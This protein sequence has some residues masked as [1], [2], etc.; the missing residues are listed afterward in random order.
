MRIPFYLVLISS[1]A[2]CSAVPTYVDPVPS[3]DT[4]RIRVVSTKGLNVNLVA[5]PNYEGHCL[6]VNNAEARSIPINTNFGLSINIPKKIGMPFVDEHSKSFGTEYYVSSKEPMVFTTSSNTLKG[7][8]SVT[9]ISAFR[10]QFEAGKDY[11]I[12]LYPDPKSC[13]ASLSD[14]TNFKPGDKLDVINLDP[15]AVKGSPAWDTL[16]KTSN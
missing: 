9:C 6:K 4:A 8:T 7:N 16:C 2:A 13:V 14:I 3:Q 5:Y 12:S 11:Q 1:L 15:I 10:Y